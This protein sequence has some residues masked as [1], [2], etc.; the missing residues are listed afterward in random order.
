MPKCST[1]SV[2]LATL[3]LVVSVS[4]QAPP[5]TKPAKDHPSSFP[6]EPFVVE[7]LQTKVR[8]ESDGTGSRELVARI[9]IQ[10]E[11]SLRDRG[12]L[13]V[14]PGLHLRIDHAPTVRRAADTLPPPS[15]TSQPFRLVSREEKMMA[16]CSGIR[17]SNTA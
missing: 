2:S 10:S 1:R 15:T 3:L 7:F 6:T 9:H 11:A 13:L 5:D 12:V 16:N 8:F 14:E 4:A 17:P